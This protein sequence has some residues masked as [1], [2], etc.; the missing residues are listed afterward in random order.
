MSYL[1]V[2]T[3][4]RTLPSG[5]PLLING[6]INDS[7]PDVDRKLSLENDACALQDFPIEKC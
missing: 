6:Q 2:R 5:T 7:R 3:G 1:T 4:S